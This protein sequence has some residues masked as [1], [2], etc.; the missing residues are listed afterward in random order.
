[1]AS[2]DE[3]RN[4]VEEKHRAIK[5]GARSEAVEYQHRKGKLTARE[6][7]SELCDTES[8]MEFG[9]LALPADSDELRPGF[10]DAVVTGWATINGQ[11]V[12]IASADFT[13]NG[14]SNGDVGLNKMRRSYERAMDNGTP[15]VQLLEGVGH[16]ISEGLDSRLFAPGFDVLGLQAQM[17]GWVPTPTAMLGQ[18]FAAMTLIA[19]MSDFVVLVRNLSFMGIAPPALVKAAVGEDV[20]AEQLGGAEIQAHRN[21]VADYVVDTE[22][23]ALDT[24]KKYLTYFPANSSHPPPVVKSLPADPEFAERLPTVVPTNMRYPYDVRHVIKGIID[25]DSLL[26]IKPGYA[27]NMVCG[28]TRIG[29]RSVG[30]VANQPN[31]LAGSIDSPA[32]DKA[33]HFVSLCDAFGIS[34]LFMLDLPGFIAGTEAE[35]S[36]LARRSAKLIYE[37]A[38]TTVPTYNIVLRKAYGGAYMAMNGGRT[39]G[40]AMTLAWPTAEFAAMNVETAISVAYKRQ[41]DEAA[42]P[43]DARQNIEQE[44]RSRL[45]PVRA[46]EGFGIDDVILPEQTRAMLVQVFK[47]APIRKH[48]KRTTPR[49]RGITPI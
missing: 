21:G 23:D 37:I 15:M 48:L 19:S 26:E 25:R 36:K 29:G 22:I 39:F 42:D 17:S 3:L 35:R 12:T 44:I 5:D 41:I 30:I 34:L 43:I 27:R 24:I 31:F 6:R 20:D 14:G 13:V 38:Q 45:G 1:M 16:R 9:G 18:G 7:I 8:F 28:L 2:H 10:A 49:L 4:I 46:A 40:A 32:C 33:S 47:A 11:P